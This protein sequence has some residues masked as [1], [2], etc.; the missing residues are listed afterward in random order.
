M[1][2]DHEHNIIII[3]IFTVPATAHS[4]CSDGDVRL[5]DGYST[6]EGRVEVCRNGYW[7]TICDN[8]WDEVD[9]NVVCK[10]LKLQ[11]YGM[12]LWY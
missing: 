12:S 3:V 2:V 8:L 10:Q 7:G 4:N 6:N 5:V 11:P 1:S 9:G